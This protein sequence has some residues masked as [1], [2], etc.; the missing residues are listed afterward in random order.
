MLR[1]AHRGHVGQV[2]VANLTEEEA[3]VL[4]VHRLSF[5]RLP[6]Q[7]LL[8]PQGQSLITVQGL[9][10]ESRAEGLWSIWTQ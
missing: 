7:L 10:V 1:S 3:T 8:Q 2:S 6:V 9:R 5:C 4:Q